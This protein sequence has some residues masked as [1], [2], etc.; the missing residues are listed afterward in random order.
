MRTSSNNFLMV[1]QRE[2]VQRCD[3]NPKYSL[4]AFARSLGVEASPLSAMLRGKRPISPKMRARLGLALGIN[5]D[6]LTKFEQ[7]YKSPDYQQIA[8][9]TYAIIADWYHYAILELTKVQDFKGTIDYISKTLNI[10]KTEAHIAVERLKRVGLLNVK[11]KRW[12]DATSEG[13]LT[14]IN[15]DLSSQASRKLQAQILQKSIL[16][17]E[18]LPITVRSH[19]S[20]TMAIDPKDLPEAKKHIQEFRRKLCTFFESNKNPKEIYHLN[21]SLYPVTKPRAQK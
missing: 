6:E 9:D 17:L 14:N 15:G 7:E 5:L 8:L 1:L 21:V 18:E 2:F 16:A 4:R 10:S 20:M 13:L 12:I 11:G 3:K 19:T